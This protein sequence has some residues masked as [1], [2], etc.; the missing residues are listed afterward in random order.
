M[1]IIAAV[2]ATFGVILTALIS[3]CIYNKTKYSDTITKTRTEWLTRYRTYFAN[4]LCALKLCKT[5]KKGDI[6]CCQILIDGESAR[7]I[8]ITMLRT[9]EESWLRNKY[10]FGLK[11]FLIKYPVELNDNSPLK[12]SDVE[13]KEFIDNTTAM[14]EDVWDFAKKETKIFTKKEKL[15]FV[16]ST[17]VYIGITTIFLIIGLLYGLS[18]ERN[19]LILFVVAYSVISFVMRASV[20]ICVFYKR[21]S[22]D[23]FSKKNNNTLINFD[24]K[25]SVSL[26]IDVKLNTNKRI[27]RI[28]RGK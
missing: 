25:N 10:N 5:L 20:F 7:L 12:P 6:K 19:C 2:I 8:L 28:K 1:E 22:E 14:L 3:F 24:F 9:R 26:G 15:I 11:Q 27:K 21:F 16:I 4:Y 13:I 17:V 23:D 18:W